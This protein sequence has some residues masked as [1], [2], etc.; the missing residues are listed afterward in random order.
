MKEISTKYSRI[1]AAFLA[2]G[3]M[4]SAGAVAQDTPNIRRLELI[5]STAAGGGTDL[6][7]RQIA[8]HLRPHVS[9]QIAI[10]NV[11]GDGSLLALSETAR[12]KPNDAVM[13]FHNFPNTI[14]SQIT[15]GENAAVNIGEDLAPLGGFAYTYTALV[16]AA[17][18][19]ISSYE[20]LQA[21]YESGEHRLLGGFDRGGNS[22]IG[23]E[24]LR[25][26]AELPFVEYIPY[27]GSGDALAAVARGEVPAVLTS[28]DRAY[29][30]LVSGTLVPL[31]ILGATERL[32]DLPDTPTTAELG[33]PLM[34]DVGQATRVIHVSANMDPALRQYLQDMWQKFFSDPASIEALRASDVDAEYIAPEAVEQ[35]YQE[36]Y[37]SLSSMPIVRAAISS[38]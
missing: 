13:I 31:L 34:A 14:L 4:A 35:I 5:V 30:G 36:T 8:E 38:N 12:S 24:L 17:D 19:G 16:T 6:L 29:D 11:P 26:S 9:H 18:S 25:E 10:R 27:D 23:A 21:A 28:S 20:E 2:L 3:L 32:P 22:E 7:I 15:R 1:R 33:Y 37:D